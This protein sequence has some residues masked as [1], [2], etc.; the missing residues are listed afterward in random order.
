MSDILIHYQKTAHFLSQ[1]L[2]KHYEIALFDFR[3]GRN[4]AIT[5]INGYISGRQTGSPADSHLCSILESGQ[6]KFQEC[7][8]SYMNS[9]SGRSVITSAMF[10][11]DGVELLGALSVGTDLN[12]YRQLA[13]DLFSI[14]NIPPEFYLPGEGENTA[15]M[16]ADVLPD[17]AAQLIDHL[18]EDPLKLLPSSRMT[19]SEKTGLVRILHDRGVFRMRGAVAAAASKLHCSEATIYRYLSKIEDGSP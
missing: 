10:I 12:R 7:H 18:L 2:G 11:T 19:A 1:C 4:C 14:A 6:W 5:I 16:A 13:A 9:D 8:G 17:H 15:A 3:H